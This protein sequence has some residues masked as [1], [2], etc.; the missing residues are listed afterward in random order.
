M[1][2]K[3]FDFWVNSNRLTCAS[4]IKLKLFLVL[5]KKYAQVILIISYVSMKKADAST[6]VLKTLL[7]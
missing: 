7:I 1:E 5:N 4:K 6:F 3:V 2:K